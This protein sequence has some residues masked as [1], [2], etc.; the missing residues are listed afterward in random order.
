M[1]SGEENKN[2]L[3]DLPPDVVSIQSGTRSKIRKITQ[4]CPIKLEN[5]CETPFCKKI[6]HLL[7]ISLSLLI[8]INC[9][10]MFSPF[11]P[12]YAESD[13]SVEPE[14]VGNITGIMY[15][16]IFAFCIV[17]GIFIK[18]LGPKFL[19]L[20][21][22]L[23]LGSSL[24]LFGLLN[25]TNTFWFIFYSFVLII[26]MSYSM[27]AI[28]TA[29]YSIGMALFPNNHNTVLSMVDTI[30]GIGYITGPIVGG[31][32]YD[33]LGW[34]WAY[35]INAV[36]V[37][38]AFITAIF[39]LPVLK[40]EKI[41]SENVKDYL[42]IFR[43]LPNINILSVVVVNMVVTIGWSYQYTSLGPFLERTYNSSSET[44]GYVFSVS[45]IGYT[46][47]LPII[48]IV[49]EKA[50]S[51]VFIWLSLPV[52]IIS[53]IL[54]P[55][56]YYIFTDRYYVPRPSIKKTLLP[57]PHNLSKTNYLSAT[58]I[59]HILVVV[60]FTLAYG[61]MYVDM[62]RNVPEK[63]RRKLSNLPEVLSSIRIATYFLATGLG[64]IIPGIIEQEYSF[65]DETLIF[66]FAAILAFVIFT[67]LSIVNL[68]FDIFKRKK[69]TLDML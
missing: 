28:Y 29:S 46:L 65:D 30:S 13:K 4:C 43:L 9:S 67:P 61:P 57:L 51:R 20:S 47:L 42:N 11:F 10:T 33:H 2:L 59:G 53:L 48:G 14:V 52:L 5:S 21:G 1:E 62:K 25:R 69:L 34:F 58:I 55:P 41:E 39:L 36:F 18:V 31:L 17:F 3:R 8:A 60:A 50:F 26:V 49:S 35:T 66:I 32:I 40:I 15:F 12:N 22:Y 6:L 56:L 54:T 16:G 23:T 68:I 19:Y 27:A 24:F 38:F 7:I 44:I 37:L 63:T 45:N 64:R